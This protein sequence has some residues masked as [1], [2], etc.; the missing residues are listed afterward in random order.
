MATYE[1]KKKIAVGFVSPNSDFK[2]SSAFDVLK[3]QIMEYT[4]GEQLFE[5][6]FYEQIEEQIRF[7]IALELWDEY[8]K[9]QKVAKKNLAELNQLLLKN[10]AE[11]LEK[12]FAKKP[13]A[14]WLNAV[15][16]ETPELEELIVKIKMA[17]SKCQTTIT[18]AIK[19]EIKRLANFKTFFE[20][21]LNEI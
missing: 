21:I 11:Q 20:Q 2:N 8:E 3:P 4:S 9:D 15:F 12:F 14:D 1:E 17:S 10:N 13:A 18:S 7:K 6:S 16:L 19:N 5:K